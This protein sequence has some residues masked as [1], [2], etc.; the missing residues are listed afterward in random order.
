VTEG[1]VKHAVV[2]SLLIWTDSCAVMAIS[3]PNPETEYAAVMMLLIL[4]HKRVVMEPHV[5]WPA[6]AN[7]VDPIPMTLPLKFAVGTHRVQIQR[8]SKNAVAVTISILPLNYV[9]TDPKSSLKLSEIS[10]VVTKCTILSHKHVVEVSKS[11]M[12]VLPNVVAPSTST[13][14][15][16]FVVQALS[17]IKEM[18]NSVVAPARM[19]RDHS[20]VVTAHLCRKMPP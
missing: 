11:Q 20:S 16:N 18:L 14:K 15:L 3:A 5:C 4:Q 19:I 12:R 8:A 1:T 13:R 6:A 9:V 10:V 17:K 7:A 2:V